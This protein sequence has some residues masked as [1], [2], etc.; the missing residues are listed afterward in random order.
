MISNRS[1][2]V[3]PINLMLLDKFAK[4]DVQYMNIFILNH[5]LNLV[6]YYYKTFCVKLPCMYNAIFD[7]LRLADVVE[8]Q[9]IVL[10]KLHI[11]DGNHTTTLHMSSFEIL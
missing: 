10:V 2:A 9:L 8:L 7:S 11:L 1:Y 5:S 3:I 6:C 4:E